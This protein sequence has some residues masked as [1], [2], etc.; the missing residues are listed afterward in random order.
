MASLYKRGN[1]YWIKYYLNGKRKERSL[2]TR[3]LQIAKE[4]KRQFES[5]Q[6]RGDD[7][8]LP[9]RTPLT[10]VLTRYVEFM[11]TIKTAKS[12]QTD[13][14]YLREAFGPI[15]DAVAITSRRTTTKKRPPKPGTDRRCRPHTIEAAFIEQ[16]ATA[17]IA[18][19]I[20]A[21]VRTKGLAPK[22]ANRY[23]EVLH[24]LFSCQPLTL[25]SHSQ[26]HGRAKLVEIIL[27]VLSSPFGEI[28]LGDPL[29][30]ARLADAGS[31]F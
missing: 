2:R 4:K 28:P 22:T 5:A 15:C 7:C 23:R 19:F 12:A 8:P 14:Y 20:T 30:L 9:T 10:D 13:T 1:V 6:A 25:R 27:H 11:H 21:Q 31:S 29:W 26:S 24:R 18:T 16:V 3:T 17:D